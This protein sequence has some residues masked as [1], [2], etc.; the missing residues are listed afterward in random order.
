MKFSIEEKEK[1]C[2]NEPCQPP[3]SVLCER[4]KKIG[5]HNRYCSQAVLFHEDQTRCKWLSYSLSK[6]CLF[7]LPCLLC[8][9]ECLRGENVCRNQGNTFTKAGYSN[10]KKQYSD[11]AKLNC[12]ISLVLLRNS[13]VHLSA[14][15]MMMMMTMMMLMTTRITVMVM[16][17][18]IMTLTT[19]TMTKSQ[20]RQITSRATM[21]PRKLKN[22][23]R[24]NSIFL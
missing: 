3:G 5:E 6:D 20:A 23:R 13:T 2:K 7:C 11:I 15:K 1:I 8:S 19:T 14:S 24:K 22:N 4:K 21:V 17:I 10:W 18:V 12:S 9:D 16:M